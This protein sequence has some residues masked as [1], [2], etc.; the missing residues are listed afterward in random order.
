RLMLIPGPRTTATP[1]AAASDPMAWPTRAMSSGSK[2]AAS[3]TAGGKQVAGS[4]LSSSGCA[5]VAASLRTPCGPSVSRICP[6]PSRCRAVVRQ[7]SAPLV[8]AAFSV[9]V[10][11]SGVTGGMGCSLDRVSVHGL[12]GDY[13]EGAEQGEHDGGG[14][15]PG[16]ADGQDN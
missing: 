11:S 16:I 3:P 15:E 8:N 13:G 12:D 5:P 1:C 6:S 9:R 2:V 4:E 7:V 10:R 14:E